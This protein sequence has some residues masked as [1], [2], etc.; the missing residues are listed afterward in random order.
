MLSRCVKQGVKTLRT[1]ANL[2]A[3]LS[4]EDNSRLGSS[5]LHQASRFTGIAIYHEYNNYRDVYKEA[6]CHGPCVTCWG[7]ETRE[8]NYSR[9]THKLARLKSPLYNWMAS[10]KVHVICIL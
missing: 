10:L 3:L 9:L 2:V 8:K 7:L 1:V 4:A 5:R 6:G